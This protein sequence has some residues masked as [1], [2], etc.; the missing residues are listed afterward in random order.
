MARHPRPAVDFEGRTLRVIGK[1]D[2]QR[3]L[4][5][6]EE[7]W[8]ALTAYLA[9]HPATSGPLVLGPAP[10]SGMFIT[11]WPRTPGDTEAYLPLVV[12]DLREAMG[13]RRYR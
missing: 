13:G 8:M 10:T 5:I 11:R 1:G 12:H 9:E 3:L 6:S 4:P 7:T 2:H